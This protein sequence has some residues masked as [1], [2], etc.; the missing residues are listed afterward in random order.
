M[1]LPRHYAPAQGTA[2]LASVTRPWTSRHGA[3]RLRGRSLI[4]RS[5]VQPRGHRPWLPLAPS[6]ALSSVPGRPVGERS[7]SP[8]G[9]GDYEQ[10]GQARLAPPLVAHRVGYAFTTQ[11]RDF[12]ARSADR[13]PQNRRPSGDLRA[14]PTAVREAGL[15]AHHGPGGASP[16]G[17]GSGRS[18]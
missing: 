9:S 16:E 14:L 5:A 2:A 18:C 11:S 4:V 6:G 12:F 13:T 1:P 10:S 17:A 15:P 8:L 7:G 3:P